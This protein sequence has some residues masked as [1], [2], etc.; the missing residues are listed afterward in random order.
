M[1][2]TAVINYKGGVGKTSV[3]ANLAAELAWL[4]YR[5]LLLD[6]DA[7]ASL[8]FSFIK[9]EIW[10][11][12][13]ADSKTIKRWFDAI[14]QQESF[15]L[16]SLVIT[17]EIA[18]SKISESG[19]GGRLD[20]IASNLGLINVDL[21]LATQL[22]GAT[23]NQTKLNYLKVHRRLAE[24]LAEISNNSYDFV[25]IDCPPNFNIVTK[26]AIV[27]S[28]NILIPAKPDYLSTLGIDYLIKSVNTLVEEYNEFSEVGDSLDVPLINPKILGVVFTM[29]EIRSGDA[30]SALRPF[31]RQTEKLG[32]PVFEQR[33]RENKTMY[34][35]APQ[36]GVPVVL[37]RYSS[38]THKDVAQ[39]L[40]TFASQFIEKSGLRRK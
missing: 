8:T 14:A 30:I 7:Q 40:E 24:G 32:L 29:V 26:N 11:K 17:P 39:E 16:N 23:L 28:D 19:N 13:Y 9:P 3:T 6:M 12:S 1:Q 18:N 22:G 20:L 37:N 27:S 34:A 4:G 25:L 21:E 36:Y 38:S 33:L 2:I 5:V 35:D 31:I 15:P 10:Q